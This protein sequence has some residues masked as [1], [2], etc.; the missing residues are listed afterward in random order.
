M[1]AHVTKCLPTLRLRGGGAETIGC[2]RAVRPSAIG[3]SKESRAIIAVGNFLQQP[4]QSMCAPKSSNRHW[5][6]SH[7]HGNTWPR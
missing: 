1:S 2:R 3:A 5:K 6:G 7:L 4:L